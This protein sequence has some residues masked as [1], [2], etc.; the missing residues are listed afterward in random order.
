MQVMAVYNRFGFILI[1]ALA[2][3]SGLKFGKEIKSPFDGKAYQSNNRYFRATGSGES[4]SL[5]V[6]KDKALLLTKQRLASAVSTELKMVAERYQSERDNL[7]ASDFGDRFQALTREVLST[8]L[9]DIRTIGDKT[10]QKDDGSFITYIALEIKKKDY[11]K[12][13]EV[14]AKNK[15]GFSEAEKTAIKHM[16]DQAIADAEK[17]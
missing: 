3:C 10:F 6:S 1:M 4:K 17:D 13:L 16:I 15:T 2:A 8:S 11:Y 7:K 5:E 12:L 14:E 9:K